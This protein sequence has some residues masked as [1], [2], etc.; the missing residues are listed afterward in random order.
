MILSPKSQFC[1][2]TCEW[3]YA[4]TSNPLQLKN[5]SVADCQPELAQEVLHLWDQ[6]LHFHFHFRPK[7]V[8]PGK[9][10]IYA[11]LVYCTNF[12]AP[13][14]CINFYA[15]T[16]SSQDS[17]IRKL[18]PTRRVCESQ[19]INLIVAHHHVRSSCRAKISNQSPFLGKAEACVNNSFR[20][21]MWRLRQERLQEIVPTR[22][23][24]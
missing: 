20:L 4:Q 13:T 23:I 9:I 11:P 10:A 6:Q 24:S 19:G 8:V 18:L 22:Q 12:Y 16:T 3:L 7:H 1:L 15:P 2:F 14:I 21:N 5:A 17:K